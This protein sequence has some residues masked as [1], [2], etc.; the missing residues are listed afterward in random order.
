MSIAVLKRKSQVLYN[1]LSV[2]T[3]TPGTSL[4]SAH[5]GKLFFPHPVASTN[6]PPGGFALNGTR[7]SQGYI[8]QT[9][10]SR[11]YV[12]TLAKG[13]VLKGNGGCCGTYPIVNVSPSE[14]VERLNDPSV[15]KPSVIN[16]NGMLRRKYKWLVG[17]PQIVKPDANQYISQEIHTVQKG[18]SIVLCSDSQLLPPALPSDNKCATL[19]RNA[20]FRNYFS[21]ILS[22]AKTSCYVTKSPFINKNKSIAGLPQSEYTEKT[23]Q[24]C[25]LQK[26][27][28]RSCSSC[29]L[30][31]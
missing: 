20:L 18:K 21:S 30:P 6:A 28:S 9:S 17:G 15:V 27:A 8:G 11:H 1:N 4:N 2:G 10:L 25:N 5:S 31:N 24:P 16:T 29:P 14:F 7:R 19:P 13:N 22:G 23:S 3:K 26:P 12:R